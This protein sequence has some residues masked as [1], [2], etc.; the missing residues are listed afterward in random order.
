M[1]RLNW[2][3]A[4]VLALTLLAF[5]LRM[6]RVDAMSVWTDEGLSIYRARAPLLQNLRG[7]IDIQGVPTTD[8][9]PPLYFLMLSGWSKLTGETEFALRYLS[10]IA[11]TLIV[12]VAYVTG[13]R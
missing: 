2:V 1:K 13:K 4:L 3:P 10:V 8:T 6:Y 9:H 12:P 7:E 11:G 5:G